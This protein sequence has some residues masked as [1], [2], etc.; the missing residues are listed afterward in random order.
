MGHGG[1][2]QTSWRRAT[3]IKMRQSFGGLSGITLDLLPLDAAGSTI[4]LHPLPTVAHR[5]P[6]SIRA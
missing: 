3:T 1:P 5:V 2:Y 4:E 6:V